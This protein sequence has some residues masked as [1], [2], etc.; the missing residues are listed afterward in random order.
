MDQPPG[1]VD[2][3]KPDYVCRLHKAVYGLKQAPRAWYTELRTFLLGLSFVNSLADTSLF[4][5][6]H[7]NQFIYLL[8]YVD[9][10]LITGNTTAGIA[11]VL[12][13]LAVRFSVKDAEQ[14]NYFLGIKAHCTSQ[15]LHLSQRKYI[16]D[17]LHR[18]DM[19]NTKPV[20]TP[21]ASS[22]KLHLHSG[23]PLVDA[24]K[25][26]RLIGS[27]QYL[28]FTRLDIAYAVN[29]L[30]QFMHMP[31]EDHWKVAKRILRYLAGTPTHGVFFSTSNKLVLHAYSDTDWGGDSDDYISTNAYVIYLGQH[32]ISWTSKK[33]NGVARSSTEAEYRAV[34][35]K[36]S[37][38]DWICNVLSELGITLSSPPLVFCDNVG[39]TFLCANS[40]IHSRMK[41]ITIDY[42]FVRNQVQLRGS[43]SRTR[44]H[45]RSTC[46]RPYQTVNS[47]QIHRS[48]QQDWSETSL[49]ILRG[50]VSRYDRDPTFT[51]CNILSPVLESSC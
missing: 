41:H 33:Q 34:A 47:S 40:V 10:I 21:M 20:T 27:L 12:R 1:F 46:R 8:I 22:P 13:M 25:Y 18:Y 9:D 50:R 35:N 24:T 51:L 30:S 44:Q 3:D 28:Q 6:R 4:V 43:Q 45:S 23:T 7:E 11:R 5:L 15:G 2:S 19:T 14:L 26:R 36:A 32:P 48:A 29:K 31:T 38:L 49:S 42:H 37:E 17:L 16:M 39:A